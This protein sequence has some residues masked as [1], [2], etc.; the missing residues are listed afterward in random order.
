MKTDRMIKLTYVL[1]NTAGRK[2][3]GGINARDVLQH[4]ARLIALADVDGDLNDKNFDDD[5]SDLEEPV[6][7]FFYDG[8]ELALAT[9][10][11]R[12]TPNVPEGSEGALETL[13]PNAAPPAPGRPEPSETVP[14]TKETNLER[15]LSRANAGKAPKRRRH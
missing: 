11:Q 6:H 12:R 13:S 2:R 7:E 15:L 5:L 8:L 4:N 3:Q 9:Q 14:R 1:H 10:A